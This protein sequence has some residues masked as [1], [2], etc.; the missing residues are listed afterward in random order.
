MCKAWGWGATKK[1]WE[2]LLSL[3][4]KYQALHW[5][6]I[7]MFSHN[8]LSCK[9]EFIIT[10]LGEENA[11]SEWSSKLPEVTQPVRDKASI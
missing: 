7:Y 9:S 4:S 6:L 10:V 8:Q 11:G 3:F 5:T 2:E 1:S